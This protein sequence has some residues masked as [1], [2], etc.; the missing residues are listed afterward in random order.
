MAQPDETTPKVP[1]HDPHMESRRLLAQEQ[2]ALRK[3]PLTPPGT[4]TL[5]QEREPRAASP[6]RTDVVVIPMPQSWEE[7]RLL[8]QKM[9][10]EAKSYLAQATDIHRQAE[11]AARVQQPHTRRALADACRLQAEANRIQ[12]EANR[13]QAEAI[14]LQAE[15]D[16]GARAV[17]A[18]PMA[19][20]APQRTPG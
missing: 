19:D 17:P 13:S 12:A 3:T 15:A 7:D 9:V 2:Q 10:M 16:A 1:S 18:A 14:R 5:D 11:E 6:A 8:P 4:S 20:A